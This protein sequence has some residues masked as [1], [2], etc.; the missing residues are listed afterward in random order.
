MRNFE[1]IVAAAADNFGIGIGG[2][3]PWRL[4][5]DLAFF[6]KKTQGITAPAPAP[7]PAPAGQVEGK[8]DGGP[9]SVVATAAP[10]TNA[11]I[12]GRKTWESIPAKFRP[13][14]GRLNVVLSR[15]PQ[16]R[17]Q[18]GLP[19]EVL[20]ADSLD[21]AL[22]QLATPDMMLAVESVF[23]IGGGAVYAEA[24]RSPHCSRI[25]LTSVEQAYKG[26]DAFFPTIPAHMYKL[27]HYSERHE[28][29]GVGC[30]YVYIYIC[31][32]VSLSLLCSFSLSVCMRV[33][34]FL[35]L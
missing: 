5:G 15:N 33:P 27:A 16:A 9:A 21:N 20:L 32:Y 12:M 7:A 11:V 30:V 25:H 1:C 26:L 17:E 34:M 28:E 8:P 3:M 35:R 18:L 2:E 4:K 6:K 24:V 31:T 29:G 14:P 22:A 10:T 19:T 13:L 23:I